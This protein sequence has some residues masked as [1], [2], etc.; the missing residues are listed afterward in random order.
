MFMES[1][2]RRVLWIGPLRE[3]MEGRFNIEQAESVPAALA[4][5][6]ANSQNAVVAAMPSATVDINQLEANIK[7]ARRK[8]LFSVLA[9]VAVAEHDQAVIGL[10]H[11]GLAPDIVTVQLDF[12]RRIAGDHAVALAAAAIGAGGVGEDDELV[13]A[14]RIVEP[15]AGEHLARPAS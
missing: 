1:E 9:L 5:L 12:S 13:Y 3:R 14:V 11:A 6:R 10:D 2:R 15:A 7:K 8:R 4:K